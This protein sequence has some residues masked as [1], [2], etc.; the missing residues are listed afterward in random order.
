MF[1]LIT[2]K[3]GE[4]YVVKRTDIRRIYQVKTSKG[5]DTYIC[6]YNKRVNDPML[7]EGTPADFY[8]L[9]LEK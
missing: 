8:K 4:Q 3:N 1:I 2:G 6:F 7:I 5:L 9:Y